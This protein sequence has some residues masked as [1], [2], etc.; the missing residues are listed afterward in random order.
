MQDTKQVANKIKKLEKTQGSQGNSTAGLREAGVDINPVQG[1]VQ[2]LITKYLN[3]NVSTMSRASVP[4]PARK[5]PR[6][7]GTSRGAGGRRQDSRGNQSFLEMWLK[8]GG[9][10][11]EARRSQERARRV[12][13]EKE[14][15]PQEGGKNLEGSNAALN[16][17]GRI[18]RPKEGKRFGERPTE[19]T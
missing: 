10:D 17:E 5:R 6:A 7:G 2:N 12:G 3:V 15:G 11:K 19:K 9:R 8:E 18:D 16:T 4:A 14:E 13:P 1:K